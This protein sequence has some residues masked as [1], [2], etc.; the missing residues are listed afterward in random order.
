MVSFEWVRDGLHMEV[1]LNSDLSLHF[2]TDSL[3]K[4]V[5]GVV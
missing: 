4:I 2:S 5:C 3:E 1:S